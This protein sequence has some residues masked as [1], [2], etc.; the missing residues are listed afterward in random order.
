MGRGSHLPT[1]ADATGERLRTSPVAM[2]ISV[3][4]LLVDDDASA[5]D[6]LGGRARKV[7]RARLVVVDRAA[8]A[9]DLDPEPINAAFYLERSSFQAPRP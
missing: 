5:R 2:R 7:I 8:R 6:R 4:R 1:L 9:P 3:E